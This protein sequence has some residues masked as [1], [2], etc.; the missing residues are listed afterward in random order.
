MAGGQ[1]RDEKIVS[2]SALD[3]TEAPNGAE[4]PAHAASW[5]WQATVISMCAAAG[6][7]ECDDIVI[8]DVLEGIKSGR[9]REAVEQVRKTYARAYETAV[10]EANPDP[11]KVAKDA[12][13]SLKKRLPG[14]TPSGRFAKRASAEILMYSGILC[15]D[16]DKVDDP[17]P[18]REKFRSDP[19]VLTA[20]VSPSAHGLKVWVRTHPDASLHRASFFAAKRYFRE[21][22]GIEIDE[23]CKDLARLCFVSHDPNIHIRT[24]P[25]ALLEPDASE[26]D[27]SEPTAFDDDQ[28]SQLVAKWG[29]PYRISLSGNILCGALCSGKHRS[30]RARRAPILHL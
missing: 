18:L 15:L 3:E 6:I 12:V 14:V 25:V 23:D 27:H 8:S 10:K 16:I 24:E 28:Y 7:T 9:W 11:H 30:A 5:N 13:N 22:H 29:A 19:H 17:T 20:F 1:A 2:T 21:T 4:K 26:P